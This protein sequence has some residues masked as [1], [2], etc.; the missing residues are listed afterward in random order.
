MGR[1]ERPTDG[2]CYDIWLPTLSVGRV[3][4]RRIQIPPPIALLGQILVFLL[5][6]REAPAQQ[7][8]LRHYAVDDGLPSSQV[9]DVTQDDQGRMWFATRGGIAAYD[10]RVWQT[11]SLAQGLSWA[12]QF[13]LRWDRDGGLWSVSSIAPFR[14]FHLEGKRWREFPGPATVSSETRITAFA[15]LGSGTTV[16]L[17]IGTAEDGVLLGVRG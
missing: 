9:R 6:A 10:G 1:T 14:I 13:A 8:H 11:Y 12:D 17:V 3:L 4:R 5:A 7:Y 15:V 2:F 16:R